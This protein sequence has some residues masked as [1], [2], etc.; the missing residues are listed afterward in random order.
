MASEMI[1]RVARGIEVEMARLTD[2]AI[3]AGQ[4]LSAATISLAK[5][6]ILV[7]REPTEAMITAGRERLVGDSTFGYRL[8][9]DDLDYIYEAMIDAA[10]KE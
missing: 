10:V 7:L 6:A 3:I 4:P 9:R 8:E 5:A 1:E 2:G